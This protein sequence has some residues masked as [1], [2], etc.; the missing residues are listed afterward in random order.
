MMLRVCVALCSTELASSCAAL[1]GTETAAGAG[2]TGGMAEWGGAVGGRV[3]CPM[4]LRHVWYWQSVWSCRTYAM[5]GTEIAYGLIA[6]D[7]GTWIA[8]A[9]ARAVLTVSY[10]HLRA[11]ETE[12]DL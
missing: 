3:S 10:T 8:R 7:T 1:C 2:K 6:R 4:L 11:H 12:A 9:A 5:P